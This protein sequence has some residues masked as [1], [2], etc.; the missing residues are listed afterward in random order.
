MSEPTPEKIS[1]TRLKL[2]QLEY[3]VKSDLVFHQQLKDDPVGKL[4]AE[5]FDDPM[6][7]RIA[8][9]LTGAVDHPECPEDICDP[10]TCIV[11][12]CC[13]WTLVEPTEPKKA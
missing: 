1:E 11:T 7:Q 9:Q 3:R 10:W 2:A 13:W 4:Q 12:G 5:G 6:A 8:G